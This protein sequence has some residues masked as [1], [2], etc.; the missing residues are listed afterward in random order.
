MA[1]ESGGSETWSA[2]V[3]IGLGLWLADLLVI[4]FAPAAIRLGHGASFVTIIIV[5]AIV[6]LGVILL[7]RVRRAV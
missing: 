7:G 2:L 4:F 3:F 1:A 5:L 6:G